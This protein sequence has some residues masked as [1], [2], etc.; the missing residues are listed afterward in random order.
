MSQGKLSGTSSGST[1]GQSSGNDLLSFL[2]GTPATT[3]YN[4]PQYNQPQYNAPQ[5]YSAPTASAGGDFNSM[6]N[7]ILSPQQQQNIAYAGQ[8]VQP[9]GAPV[10]PQPVYQTPQQTIGG[11]IG[12]GVANSLFGPSQSMY[13]TP[14]QQSVYHAPVTQ[15]AYAMAAPR[16]TSAPN[17]SS[18]GFAPNSLASKLFGN[19]GS[20]MSKSLF[21][22][23]GPANLTDPS[24]QFTTPPSDQPMGPTNEELGYTPPSDPMQ[25][26]YNFENQNTGGDFTGPG[27]F[28]ISPVAPVD[29]SG[30]D[31]SGS[32]DFSAPVIDTS[33][34]DFGG[35]DFSGDW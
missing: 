18:S 22:G 25:T 6:M 16:A 10:T 11:A 14:A 4:Q 28:N 21:G 7:S 24:Q 34:M 30:G 35:G 19:M 3:Q 1:A 20:S 13:G 5:N 31:W 8:P 29:T 12:S 26:I 2:F 23:G 33:N 27:D 9:Y 15:P 17:S 32:G